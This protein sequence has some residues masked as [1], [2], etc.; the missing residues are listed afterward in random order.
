MLTIA[1]FAACLAS[2]PLAQ[3]APPPAPVKA[4][5]AAELPLVLL[6]HDDTVITASCRLVAPAHP[7]RDLN[8]NGVVQIK[9][10]G[11]TVDLMGGTLFGADRSAPPDSLEG[12]GFVVTGQKVT[13]ANGKVRGFRC[14]VLAQQSN[15]STFE[16]L[17]LSD[18]VAD[19]LLSTPEAED[20]ADWLWPHKNDQ[21]QWVTRYGAGLCIERSS[22]VTVRDITVRRT[23][24]GILLDRVERSRIY[25][26]DCSYLSGWG[27]AL[28]RSSSNVIC[29]NAFDFCIRGYS[30]EKY[31]RGQDSAGILIFEQCKDNLIA[32]N[33]ATHCGDGVFGFAGREALGEDP[34]PAGSPDDFHK[35]RGSNGNR[36]IGNDF[37]FAAAH[38]LEMTFSFG[39]VVARNQFTGNNLAGLWAGYCRDT[40]VVNNTFSKNGGPEGPGEGGGIDIEHGQ[41]NRIVGNEFSDEKVAIELWSDEDAGLR[42]L[43]WVQANGAGS[44]DNELSGNRFVRCGQTILL[45]DSKNDK[46]SDNDQPP[47]HTPPPT[48]A[49]I[50]TIDEL[51]STLPGLNNPIG[52]R[53]DAGGREAIRV[54]D[55]WPWDGQGQFLSLHTAGGNR[56]VWRL[57]GGAVNGA[58]VFGGGPLRATRDPANNQVLVTS[59]RT[60]YVMPYFLRV[61]TVGGVPDG[62]G[63]LVAADWN[64]S[65]FPSTHDPL[66]D[67]EAWRKLATEADSVVV[68]CTK[69]DFPFGEGGPASLKLGAEAESLIREAKLPKDHF[70]LIAKT[71][72]E[73][74]PGEFL[75]RV[76]SDD[77]VRVLVD[78]KPVLEDWSVHAPR[79][80]R[81]LLTIAERRS[82]DIV[83]EYFNAG[84]NGT[85]G[86]RIDGNLEA[87][88]MPK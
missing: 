10:D 29:R 30:H 25:D 37:S 76:S 7:I 69:I 26:N 6:E 12:T 78:G 68:E 72:L 81:A 40:L 39:N 64:V 50:P 51:R 52:K 14:G 49:G 74:P 66:T 41:R 23:Q 24:N 17:D 71:T 46:Q 35:G 59:E 5:P 84:G 53:G 58:Q 75:L 79:E 1:V 22:E 55:F 83:V 48:L 21:R 19:R 8:G 85:L 65:L 3:A 32:L 11:I 62:F 60:G 45:R 4:A 70:G 31:S 77:G 57:F 88:R 38:G 63:C 47:G 2:S 20:G 18:N 13:L 73:F 34:P 42:K 36:F 87:D 9:G 61:S 27:L 82:V 28:W 44:Q 33:S 16:K 15:G 80:S 43:G 56:D 86:M 67:L 54:A